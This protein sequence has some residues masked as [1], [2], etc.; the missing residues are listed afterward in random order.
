MSSTRRRSTRGYNSYG[1]SSASFY[2][3]EEQN[4]SAA[5][6]AFAAQ[7]SALTDAVR[8]PTLEEIARHTAAGANSEIVP[9]NRA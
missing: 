7:S 1:T 8:P 9:L 2:A 5:R 4:I 6:A 3:R